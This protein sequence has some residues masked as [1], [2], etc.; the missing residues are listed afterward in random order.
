MTTIRSANEVWN[1]EAK[2]EASYVNDWLN[3]YFYNSLDSSIQDNILN[4]TF[5]IGIYTDVDEITTTKKVGL[6]D[7]VQYSRA[8]GKNSYLDIKE[9]WWTGNYYDDS[10]VI[11]VKEEGLTAI[12]GPS[13]GRSIRAVI[14]ISN[15]TITGWYSNL[16]L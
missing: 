16:K 2:Y 10:N 15:I 1:T 6:L 12:Q 9:R 8:G 3:N 14:K 7:I 4:S 11:N 13:S 5:N